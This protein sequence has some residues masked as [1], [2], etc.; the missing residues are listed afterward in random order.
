MYD[1]LLPLFSGAQPNVAPN[2]AVFQPMQVSHESI[3][4]SISDADV[5]EALEDERVEIE[6]SKTM[7]KWLVQKTAN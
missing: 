1:T 4:Q 3:D 6:Q 2:E 5:Q 7:P